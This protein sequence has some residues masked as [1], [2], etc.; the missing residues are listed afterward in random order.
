[1]KPQMQHQP[2]PDQ[3]QWQEARRL[4]DADPAYAPWS[5][6]IHATETANFDEWLDS[7]EGK[8]WLE[9]EEEKA[10]SWWNHDGFNQEVCGH[11]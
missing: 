6:T 8:N 10:G 4:L 5:E 1:M 9:T 2:Q 3:Q 7:P 11:A